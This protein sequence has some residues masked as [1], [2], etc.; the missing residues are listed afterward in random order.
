M[1][2]V[3]Q[4]QKHTQV[5]HIFRFSIFAMNHKPYRHSYFITDRPYSPKQQY[6]QKRQSARNKNKIWKRYIKPSRSENA[7]A[8]KNPD[9]WDQLTTIY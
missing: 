1:H 4:I 8:K 6:L 2:F 3:I 5:Q 9:P 7:T